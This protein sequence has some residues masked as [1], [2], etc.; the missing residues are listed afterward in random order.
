MK[1]DLKTNDAAKPLGIDKINFKQKFSA[2][3]DTKE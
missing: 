3:K 1:V 2:F